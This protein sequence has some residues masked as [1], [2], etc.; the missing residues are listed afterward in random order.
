MTVP[1]RKTSPEA[2]ELAEGWARRLADSAAPSPLCRV[3]RDVYSPFGNSGHRVQAVS[4]C[5][6]R[7]FSQIQESAANGC[8]FC[9]VLKSYLSA[10]EIAMGSE[11]S[12]LELNDRVT[13]IQKALDGHMLPI[14]TLPEKENSLIRNND[15]DDLLGTGSEGQKT[16]NGCCNEEPHL[17]PTSNNSPSSIA[18]LQ[19]WLWT[20]DTSHPACLPMVSTTGNLPARLIDLGVGRT[21]RPLLRSTNG[22]SDELVYTT[23]SHCW[24]AANMLRT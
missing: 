12:G 4:S 24:G 13:Q 5:P 10:S 22:L 8:H 6:T 9:W 20:C 3:C 19:Q 23:L 18:L 15:A 21:I 17:S 11:G 7:T 14:E 2:T 1:D 16:R